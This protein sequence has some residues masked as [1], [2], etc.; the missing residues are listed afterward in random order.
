MKL[1]IMYLK[2]KLDASCRLFVYKGILCKHALSVLNEFGEEILSQYI[3]LRWCKDF[4]RKFLLN[5]HLDHSDVRNPVQ[6]Y[7]IL[8]QNAIQL[9]DG[10]VL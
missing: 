8:Y 7:D 2:Y 1:C 3:L 5:H 6:H 10:G 9:V 4:K